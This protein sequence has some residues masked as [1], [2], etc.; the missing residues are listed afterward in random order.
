MVDGVCHDAA[1]ASST[2]TMAWSSSPFEVNSLPHTTPRFGAHRMDRRRP[3]SVSN[4]QWWTRTGRAPGAPEKTPRWLSAVPVPSTN[5]RSLSSVGWVSSSVISNSLSPPASCTRVTAPWA[6]PFRWMPLLKANPEAHEHVPA[7][8]TT[9][10][11]SAAAA[12]AASTSARE[13]EP[14]VRVAPRSA[15][16]PR[17]P[18]PEASGPAAT[19][20]VAPSTMHTKRRRA[21]IRALLLPWVLLGSVTAATKRTR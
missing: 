2:N 11:P 10:S 6:T 19:S 16:D 14:A 7:G 8:T 20:A 9:V 15:P 4:T 3:P 17:P 13:Q 1:L 21:F 18:E 12:T 5:T